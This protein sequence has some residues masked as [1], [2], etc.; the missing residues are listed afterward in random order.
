[1]LKRIK[2]FLLNLNQYQ[3]N[4]YNK[5]INIKFSNLFICPNFLS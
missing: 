1:M 3:I 4:I 2:I 5:Q